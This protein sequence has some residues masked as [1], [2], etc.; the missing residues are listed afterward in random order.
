MNYKTLTIIIAIAWT[1]LSVGSILML[2]ANANVPAEK[3]KPANARRAVVGAVLFFTFFLGGLELMR[4][5]NRK[6]IESQEYTKAEMDKMKKLMNETQKPMEEELERLR[7]V[8]ERETRIQ[9]ETDTTE[10]P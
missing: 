4:H 9:T 3:R 6:Y 7:D 1:I 10:N 2:Y 8:Q 5:T